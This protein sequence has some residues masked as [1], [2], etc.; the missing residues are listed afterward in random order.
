M[1]RLKAALTPLWGQTG[2]G[3]GF[4]RPLEPKQTGAR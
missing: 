1:G 4:S 2:V 3:A